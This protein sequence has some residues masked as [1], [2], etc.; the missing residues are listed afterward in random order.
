[1]DE[2]F[3]DLI[4]L[5]AEGPDLVGRAGGQ[6][7]GT[8][9]AEHAL[10]GHAVAVQTHHG[11]EQ[12]PL[13]P[14]HNQL[15]EGGV[16]GVAAVE[17]ADVGRPPRDARDA[18]VEARAHLTAQRCKVGMDVARPDQRAVAGGACPRAAQQVDHLVL[19]LALLAVVEGAG[20]ALGV[21]I[22][23]LGD[24][25]GIVAVV[26]KVVGAVLGLGL[27][28]PEDLDAAVVVVFLDLAPQ[29]LAG[30]GVGGVKEHGVLIDEA[31]LAVHALVAAGDVALLVHFLI[32]L[33]QQRDLRPDG[34]HQLHAHLLELAH[35]CL[36]IGPELLI[37]AEVA[38]VR[39][40][41]EVHH[42]HVHRD[43]AAVVLA[44]DG[45]QLLLVPVA[46]LALPEAQAV[47]GHGGGVTH[48]VGVG[49]LD[50]G[51]GIAGA[52]PVVHLPG[53]VGDPLHQ[54]FAK[55]RAADGGVVPQEAVALAGQHEGYAGLRVAVRQLEGGV[56]D[57]EHV[58]LV[59][60]HAV[61]LLVVIGCKA[62]GELVVAR[63]DGLE[64]A[65]LYVERAGAGTLGQQHVAA[66]VVVGDLEAIR[67]V[68]AAHDRA[69][70]AHGD[71]GAAL[72]DLNQGIGALRLEQRPGGQ[73][74]LAH[75]TRNHAQRVPAPREQP[76][77]FAEKPAL[78]YAVIVC[79]QGHIDLSF[80][81]MRAAKKPQ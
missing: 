40:V 81:W 31:H 36:G 18:H 53:A 46:Q 62:H 63:D 77:V 2:V 5:V 9:R 39:P 59:L 17:A 24:G 75:G 4:G 57:V 15:A 47:L 70:L 7:L 49:G 21:D 54:V 12:T 74:G 64:E 76:E 72:G 38:H 79:K 55:A 67:P 26:V 25:A 51:G 10:V 27:V 8:V 22:A 11:A 44:R 23:R 43:A 71:G 61:E 60:A 19:T 73:L 41:E 35:H 29:V 3:D 66:L 56:F 1:M 50:L 48:G 14:A 37:E 6:A 68:H 58:L 34:D 52:D 45:E 30:V 28:Q 78:E 13:E 42:D 33:G 20:V 32:I 69:E 65:G 80:I 16:G